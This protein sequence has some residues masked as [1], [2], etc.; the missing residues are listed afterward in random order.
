MNNIRVN[1]VSIDNRIVV[2]IRHKIVHQI[3]A[4]T[5]DGLGCR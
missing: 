5:P 1:E 3:A 4:P 2:D